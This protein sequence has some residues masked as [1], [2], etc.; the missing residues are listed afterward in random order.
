MIMTQSILADIANRNRIRQEAQLPLLDV[1]TEAA[2]LAAVR[3]QAEFEIEWE[4]RRPEFAQWIGEANGFLSKMGR[5]SFA[6]QQVRKDIEKD[7]S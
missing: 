2:R 3:E 4:K 5:Q 1:Q 7:Q 6:R